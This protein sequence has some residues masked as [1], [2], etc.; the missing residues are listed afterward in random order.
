MAQSLSTGG[1]LLRARQYRPTRSSAPGGS[2]L[3]PGADQHRS[4]GQPFGRRHQSLA[5]QEGRARVV[6]SPLRR[7]WRAATLKP[8]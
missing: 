4:P 3:I 5:G 6:T 8:N 2:P 1:V 7:W